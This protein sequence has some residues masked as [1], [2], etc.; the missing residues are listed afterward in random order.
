MTLGSARALH[1]PRPQPI[2]RPVAP[3]TRLRRAHI[4]RSSSQV[5]RWAPLPRGTGGGRPPPPRALSPAGADTAW[6]GLRPCRQQELRR[7][8]E[9]LAAQQR[10]LRAELAEVEA[11]LGELELSEEDRREILALLRIDLPSAGAPEAPAGSAGGP[12]AAPPQQQQLQPGGGLGDMPPEVASFR[13]AAGVL[14]GPLP[15]EAAEAMRRDY[16]VGGEGGGFKPGA[17]A[18][19]MARVIEEGG[20]LPPLPPETFRRQPEPAAEFEARIRASIADWEGG[21]AAAKSRKHRA[22]GQGPQPLPEPDWDHPF[23]NV[24]REGGWGRAL[25][26]C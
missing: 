5:D 13:A 7:R 14:G 21:R 25:L 2:H 1:G 11:G 20:Q 26:A 3:A 16:G 23:D 9:Q 18:E 19:D 15:P 4:P 8:A 12:A 6:L 22:P 24:R 17:G 10:A